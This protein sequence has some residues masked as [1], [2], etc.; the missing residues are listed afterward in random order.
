MDVA[1]PR[2]RHRRNGPSCCCALDLVSVTVNVTLLKN[3][4]EL[5]TGRSFRMT[6]SVPSCR[7]TAT[8]PADRVEAVQ[9]IADLDGVDAGAGD[10]G[11]RSLF[12][13]AQD[14]E[15]VAGRAAVDEDVVHEVEAGRSPC[16]SR[17]AGRWVRRRSPCRRG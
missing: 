13:H 8:S 1:V 2:R 17:R 11:Q 7:Q 16:G 10:Q 3:Q 5:S 15:L 12:A 4:S 9:A 6:V 14:V